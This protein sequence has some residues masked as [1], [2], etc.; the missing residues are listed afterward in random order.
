MLIVNNKN[1]LLSDRKQDFMAR[2]KSAF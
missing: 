1:N 2:K